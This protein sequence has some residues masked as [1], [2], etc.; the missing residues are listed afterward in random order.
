LILTE[1]DE[2][3]PNEELSVMAIT[4]TFADPPPLFCVPL[5]WHP[6]EHPVTKLHQRSAAVLNWLAMIH[7]TDVVGYGGDVPEKI[8]RVIRVRLDEMAE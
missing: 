8:M 1:N 3:S 6:R 2:I 4:T 7:P 5:P